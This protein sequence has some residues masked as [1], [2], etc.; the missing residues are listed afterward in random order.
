MCTTSSLHGDYFPLL[1][2]PSSRHLHHIFRV[3]YGVVVPKFRVFGDAYFYTPNETLER[4]EKQSQHALYVSVFP[5]PG[6]MCKRS[7]CTIFFLRKSAISRPSFKLLLKVSSSD[8]EYCS[9]ASFLIFCRNALQKREREKM[10]FH[11]QGRT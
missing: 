8:T 11:K 7:A 4:C 3:F 6:C 2:S 1:L 10:T 9:N 5:S